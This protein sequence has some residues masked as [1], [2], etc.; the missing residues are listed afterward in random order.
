MKILFRLLSFAKPYR[1]FVP[2]YIIYVVPATIFGVL[3]F[4]LLIPLLDTLFQV[5]NTVAITEKPAFAFDV[6]FVVAYIGYYVNQISTIYSK[7]HALVFVCAVILTSVLLSNL[8]LYMSQRTLARMRT[9]LVFNMRKA[10]YD[11]LVTL[12]IGFFSKYRKGDILSVISAD[13]HEIE[14]NLVSTI[15]VIFKDPFHILVYLSVLIMISPK[16]TLITLVFFPVAAFIISLIGKR[17]R[18][19][20]KASQKLLGQLLSISEET[21]TGARIIR[22]FSAQEFARKSFNKV[23]DMYRKIIRAYMNRRELASPISEFLGVLTIVVIMIIGGSMVLSHNSVLTPSEFVTYVIIYSQLIPPIKSISNT[24]SNIQRGLASGERIINI[25]DSE[26]AITEKEKVTELPTFN[27][28]IEY[29]DVSFAYEEALVLRNINLVIPKGKTVALVGQSGAGKTTFVDLLPRFFDP[30]KGQ[31]LIDGVDIRDM[32]LNNLRS[33]LGIVT[34]EPILFNDTVFNNI[35][36]GLMDV[37]NEDVIKAAKIANAHDFIMEMEDGYNT[38]ISDRGTR[39]SGGQRQRI[40][41]A[42]AILRNPAILILDEATSALDTESEM[43][44]QQAIEKV[45]KDR[46]SLVIAH[47]LS[48]IINADEIVVFQKGEIVE[49]GSHHRLLAQNGVYKKLYD[50]Q[51]NKDS[52]VGD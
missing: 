27:K 12:H 10:I 3:N 8:F 48:T 1:H 44:V 51:I 52:V 22:G 38:N 16:L 13:S 47:R 18:K 35:A 36:F 37:K 24:Y 31:I 45:M 14:N 39:L 4:T 9:W 2:E 49:R 28:E 5:G 23:N 17:L 46:T 19:S 6:D 32:S 34:Q 20:A 33:H 50:L 29:R 15:Q 7:T 30:L 43:L 41:I 42:R 21:I 40:S 11:K 25:L 26:S